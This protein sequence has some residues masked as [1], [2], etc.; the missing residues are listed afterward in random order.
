MLGIRAVYLHTRSPPPPPTPALRPNL[1]RLGM[2]RWPSWRHVRKAAA[3]RARCQGLPSMWRPISLA[4]GRPG[5]QKEN[6]LVDA[7]AIPLENVREATRK[8]S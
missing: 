1:Y 7:S 6:P 2:S 4:L 5:P 3:D 8:L